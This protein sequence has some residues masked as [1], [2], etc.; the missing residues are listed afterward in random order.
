MTGRTQLPQRVVRFYG[1]TD[2]ALDAIAHRQITFIHVSLLNDPFDP[3]FVFETNFDANYD[4]LLA[5]VEKEHPDYSDWFKLHVPIEHWQRLVV[6]IK[7][8]M[9]NYKRTKFV[10][11]C[12]AVTGDQHPRDNLYMWGHYANGHRGGR[13]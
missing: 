10:F 9:D 7:S 6:D 1:N 12:S 11:S 13:H 5:Y 2:F 3:Y 4:K 8:H